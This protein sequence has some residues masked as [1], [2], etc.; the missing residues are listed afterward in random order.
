MNDIHNACTK[1]KPIIY[2]DDTNLYSTS[3]V[4]DND[5]SKNITN[6][7]QNINYELD[8]I[9]EWLTINKLSLNVKKLNI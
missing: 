7:S 9:S 3:N 6:I 5:C 4:F 8:C 2:A 1:F